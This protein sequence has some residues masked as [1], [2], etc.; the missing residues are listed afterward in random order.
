MADLAL[1]PLFSPAAGIPGSG[2]RRE[3]RQ[4]RRGSEAP[5]PLMPRKLKPRGIALLAF[6]L[7]SSHVLYLPVWGIFR[8]LQK[9]PKFSEY[10][11]EGV[12]SKL[13]IILS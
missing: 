11:Q 7:N 9:L 12:I 4:G 8:A 5:R 3:L 1:F 13:V 2:F 6:S 10:I